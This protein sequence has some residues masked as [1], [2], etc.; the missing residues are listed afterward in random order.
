MTEEYAGYLCATHVGE[1]IR[2]GDAEGW[3]YEIRAR[4]DRPTI[5][6]ILHQPDGERADG[7]LRKK[8][9][10][11]WLDPRDVVAIGDRPAGTV[12]PWSS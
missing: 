6:V 7:S 3:C 8:V 5:A 1:W 11:L 4:A 10:V 9:H 2:H 12:A